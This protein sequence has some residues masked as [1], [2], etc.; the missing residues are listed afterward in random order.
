MCLTAL[1]ALVASTLI[2]KP[3]PCGGGSRLDSFGPFVQE[4]DIMWPADR[5]VD[6]PRFQP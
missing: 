3:E 4:R 5:N 6:R 2:P 1:P